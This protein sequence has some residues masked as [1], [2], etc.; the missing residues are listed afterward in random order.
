MIF[1]V[2]NTTPWVEFTIMPLQYPG[3]MTLITDGDKCE[4]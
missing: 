1:N 4:S 2:I 3:Y